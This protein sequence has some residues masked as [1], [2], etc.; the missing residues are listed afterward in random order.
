M[1]TIESLT[2]LLRMA[3]E[4]IDTT[5]VRIAELKKERDKLKVSMSEVSSIIKDNS[6]R[7][8]YTK[9]RWAELNSENLDALAKALKDPS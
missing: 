1:Q 3:H 2:E 4:Q 8:K 7:N 5:E 6:R 9:A